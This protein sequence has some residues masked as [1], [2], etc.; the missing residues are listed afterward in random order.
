MVNLAVFSLCIEAMT[1]EKVVNVF[2]QEKVHPREILAM[3]MRMLHATGIKSTQL[4]QNPKFSRT[5]LDAV[6]VACL[7]L[8]HPGIWPVHVGDGQYVAPG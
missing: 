7:T 4:T 1:F 2:E 3:S 5:Q 8:I 6:C